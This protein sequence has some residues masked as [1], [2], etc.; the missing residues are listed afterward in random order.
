MSIF[1]VLSLVGGL[2]LFLFGMDVMGSALE[3]SAGSRLE[4]ILAKLT[5]NRFLGL[6]TGLAVTGVIQSSSATTVM[7]VG[8]VNSGLMQL[9][10]AINV[11]MGANIG[12]TVTAWILSLG[13]IEGSS[14]IL[15]LLKPDSFTPVLALIG[16]GFTMFSKSGKKKDV[17]TILLG[18]AVL[19]QGMS[20]MSDSVAGLADV[21]EFRNI[22]LMFENPVLG[23]LAGAVLTAVIQSSSASV[24]ILQA[25]SA[26]GAVT[27]GAAVPIIMGQNIGTCITAI[28]SSFGTNRNARRTAMVHLSFNVIG[29]VF[30]LTAF[31]VVEMVCAPVLFDQAATHA[32][33]ATAHSLFNIAC[34]CLLFPQTKLLEKLAYKLVPE[35]EA[36]SKITMLDERLLATPAVAL[37]RCHAVASGMAESAATA[38]TDGIACLSGF[39]Q[40]LDRSIREKEDHTDRCEDEIGNYLIRLSALQLEDSHSAQ[41]SRLLKV[42]GD[43]ERIGDHAV[44]LAESGRELSEKKTVFS[45]AAQAELKHMTDAVQEIM[46]LTCRA[47][48]EGDVQAALLAEPLEQV[49]DDLKEALRSSHIRRLQKGGC[50]IESGFIWLDV[51]TDLERIADHCANIAASVL[52]DPTIHGSAQLSRSHSDSYLKAYREYGAKYLNQ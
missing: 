38:L 42:I 20:T 34:T 21:P 7:V 11:I 36:Q 4:L 15:K 47:F 16:I 46:A 3:R 37:E 50:T 31:S 30:W 40:E 52:E 13:G 18:F 17:G 48:A 8:F 2:C 22:L 25:L 24:G 33:I 14:L 5:T 41:V 6:L 23:V 44:N 29:T 1:D 39:T 12:T 19:M 45:D 26:T 49:V 32:S 43:L 9:N 35:T 10:Q 28:L 27:I 51:L